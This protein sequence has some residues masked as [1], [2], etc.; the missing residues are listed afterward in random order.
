MSAPTLTYSGSTV[1]LPYPS[2]AG[3]NDRAYDERRVDR[4]TLGGN[5]R[6]NVIS[7][8]YIYHLAFTHEPIATYD[9]IVSLW[10]AA[11]AA[12]AYP[13]FTWNGDGSYRPFT[14]ANAVPVAVKIS[15]IVAKHDFTRTDWTLELVEVNPR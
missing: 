3:S 8:G 5:L 4:R 9:A 7:K 10:Q 15:P 14:T 12:G 1:T 13:T 11:L 2:R 6:V